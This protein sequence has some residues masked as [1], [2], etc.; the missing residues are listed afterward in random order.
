MG[1]REIQNKVPSFHH[2]LLVK[3]ED[4]LHWV[5]AEVAAKIRTQLIYKATSRINQ[6]RELLHLKTI[7]Q[8]YIYMSKNKRI[9]HINGL[10]SQTH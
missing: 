6:K 4:Y 1:F 8:I 7:N 10:V 5:S 3:L 9:L 2:F